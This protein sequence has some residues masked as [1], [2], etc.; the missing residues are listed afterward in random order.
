MGGAIV[1]DP[2][3]ATGVVIGRA[4]HDLLDQS[5]E[6]RDAILRFAAAIDSGSVDIQGS[7]VGPGTT[8][9][10]LILDTHAGAWSA[11]LRDVFPAPGLNAGL[12]IG[13]D[14]EFIVLERLL[15]PLAGVEI[16]Y[17]PGFGGEVGVSREN[18]TAVVPR[19]NGVFM[20]PAP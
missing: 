20:Q 10:I 16:Q 14:H 4:C 7:D 15:L 8:P 5:V 1:H 12:F 2:E 11:R 19:S 6:G 17:A 9:E 18:P 3:D 13:G